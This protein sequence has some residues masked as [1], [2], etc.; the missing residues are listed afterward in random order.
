VYKKFL[1]LALI[2]GAV[3]VSG[4]ACGDKDDIENQTDVQTE[5][6]TE[7][8]T[9]PETT[10]FPKLEVVNSAEES[11]WVNV[12]TTYGTFRYPAAFSDIV[13]VEGVTGEASAEL[14]VLLVTD[15]GD[16]PVYTLYYNNEENSTA[17]PCGKLKLDSETEE[18]LISVVFE[19]A[20][21]DLSADWQSTFYAVQ[22][23]FNDVIFSM[24]EDSR[25]TAAD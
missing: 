10:G 18:M 21:E 13:K 11:A 19:N 4:T 17:I 23:T 24:E 7:I 16:L 3:M 1:V 5:Q 22:E 2:L 15:E 25:F 20:P 9:E 6:Q 14:K 12:E 8:E